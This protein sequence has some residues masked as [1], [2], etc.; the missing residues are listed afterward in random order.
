MLYRRYVNTVAGLKALCFVVCPSICCFHPY[1]HQSGP[2]L[3]VQY[4]MNALGN[5]NFDSRMNWLDF[6]GHRSKVKVTL[7]VCSYHILECHIRFFG[8][9]FR[10]MWTIWT[11]CGLKDDLIQFW[12]SNVKDLPPHSSWMR[13]VMSWMPSGIF[14]RFGRNP[15]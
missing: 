13:Y 5:V 9:F 2:F 11:Y 15:Q 8:V 4:L 6:W 3:W 1:L 14:S 7:A 10:K 12:R